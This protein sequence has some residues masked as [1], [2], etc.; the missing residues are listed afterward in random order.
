M[1]MLA[2]NI[3]PPN[4]SIMQDEGFTP[5]RIKTEVLSGLI[6]NERYVVDNSYLIK[7]DVEKSGAEAVH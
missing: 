5:N 6:L 3:S 7:A 1:A 2:K 4:L